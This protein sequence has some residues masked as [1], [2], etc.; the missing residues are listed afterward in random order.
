MWHIRAASYLF[1][2]GCNMSFDLQPLLKSSPPLVHKK[3]D[4]I[5]I[6]PLGKRFVEEKVSFPNLKLSLNLKP[7]KTNRVSN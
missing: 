1:K 7:N 5:M 4:V 2:I 6:Q 3:M